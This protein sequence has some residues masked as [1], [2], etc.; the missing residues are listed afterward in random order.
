[1]STRSD[2]DNAP[3]SGANSRPA[4]GGERTPPPPDLVGK[5][6]DGRYFIERELGRGGIGAVYLARDKPELMSRPVVVKVLLEDSLKS[7]WIVRKFRQEVESLTRLDDPGVVGIFDAGSLPDGAPYLVMQFVDGV[8]LR[9]EIWPGGMGFERAADIIRQIG[10]ALAA[11]H[12][13]GIIHRDLKPENIMLRPTADG[14][15]QVKV[16]DFGI[17]KVKNSVVAPSTVTA[18]AAGTIGYMPPEQL[19]AQKITPASDVYALGVI[20]YEMMTG[21]RPFNPETGYQLLEMQRAG[22]RV[23]P[24]DLRPALPVAAQQV[25]LKAL[26]FEPKNR[27]Q[28]A[29]EFGEALAHA[30]VDAQDGDEPSTRSLHEEE[31]VRSSSVRPPSTPTP[32]TPAGL[33]LP[34]RIKGRKVAGLSLPVLAAVLLAAALAGLLTTWARKLTILRSPPPRLPPRLRRSAPSLTS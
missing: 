26:A 5:L 8:S 3:S 27:Y 11:A 6:I 20:A 33:D 32:R 7:E 14:T 30:L 24:K 19:S 21:I 10:R 28:Q 22:V 4:G 29:R 16:I 34:G 31:P 2:S 1:M 15:A 23:N 13:K 12:D 9:D 18:R 17:A 25:I